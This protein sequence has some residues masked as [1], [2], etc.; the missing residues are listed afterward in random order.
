MTDYSKT[1]DTQNVPEFWHWMHDSRN[2]THDAFRVWDAGISLW[3][4]RP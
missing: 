1:W 3:A 2:P 4:R